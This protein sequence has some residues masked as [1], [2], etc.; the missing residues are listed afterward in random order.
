MRYIHAIYMARRCIVCK[1]ESYLVLDAN[2]YPG[3]PEYFRGEGDSFRRQSIKQA[4]PSKDIW[5]LACVLSEAAIWSV[6]GAK[7]RIDYE[8]KRTTETSAI[9]SIRN[10][11]YSGCFHDGTQLLAAVLETHRQAIVKRRTNIDDIIPQVINIIERMMEQKD[12]RPTALEVYEYFTRALDLVRPLEPAAITQSPIGR[13]YAAHPTHRSLPPIFPPEGLGLHLDSIPTQSPTSILSITSAPEIQQSLPPARSFGTIWENH[14]VS[15][16]PAPTLQGGALPRVSNGITPSGR[17]RTFSSSSVGYR[18]R[19]MSTLHTGTPESASE[20]LA[21]EIDIPNASPP[22]PTKRQDLP[23]AS[24][25][26]VIEWI[27]K[28]KNNSTVRLPDQDWLKR[29]HGRDQV[30]TTSAMENICKTVT[31]QAPLDLPH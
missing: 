21:H 13:G 3:A 14:H 20:P 23:Y 31:N 17:A 12:K 18:K 28:R 16:P 4:K 15:F 29:L 10:T 25:D 22:V 8:E 19:P 11:G 1:Q 27:S 30:G 24:I 26:A 2:L 9:Q 7:G 5:S 6:F